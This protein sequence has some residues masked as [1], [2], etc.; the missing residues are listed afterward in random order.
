MTPAPPRAEADPPDSTCCL[1]A[2]SPH[3]DGTT[4]AAVRLLEQ[5][6]LSGGVRADHIRLR[7]HDVRPCIGC[8]FC[9]AHPGDCVFHDETKELF[10]R[11]D[12]ADSLIVAVPVYFYG[13][14]ALFKGF[15]DRAQTLWALREHGLRPRRPRRIARAVFC[16]ARLNGERLF[17][18]NILILRCFLDTLGFELRDPLLLREAERPA[19]LRRP[20]TIA[21][22]G[23]LGL[24][25]AEEATRF[26]H[27]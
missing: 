14:P 9:S 5:A 22:L 26:R 4:D 21:R 16:A 2:C 7:D 6:V 18:A 11:L 15:I 27:E 10:A 8:G 20:P 13:P 23:R 3:A 12:R 1:L 24:E 19:D 25:A 17:D